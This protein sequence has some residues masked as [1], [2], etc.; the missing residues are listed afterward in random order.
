MVMIFSREDLVKFIH[1][2]SGKIYIYGI[3]NYGEI[4]ATI[5]DDLNIKFSAF[6]V[7]DDKS[8][9]FHNHKVYSFN[10]IQKEIGKDDCIL[11]A[12]KE[13]FQKE[14]IDALPDGFL[15][16]IGVLNRSIFIEYKNN[17][18]L[19][20]LNELVKKYPPKPYCGYKDFR[21]IL[22]VRLDRMGDMVWTSAFFRELRRNFP[23][24]QIT[25]L[26]GEKN[27]EILKLCPYINGIITCDYERIM[28]NS[29]SFTELYKFAERFVEVNI[30]NKRF[31][32][33][34][35]ARGL[36]NDK[37]VLNTFLAVLAS[38]SIRI[39][40]DYSYKPNVIDESIRKL[41]SVVY[42]HSYPM[43]DVEKVLGMLTSIDCVV[44]RDNLEVWFPAR[45]LEEN[46]LCKKVRESRHR[47]K[48][49]IAVG[50]ISQ[51]ENKIWDMKLY[52]EL[53]KSVAQEL[54]AC[55]V[56][57][58]GSDSIRYAHDA[59]YPDNCINLAGKTNLHE[60]MKIISNC[61]IYLGAN[62]GIMHIAAALS[63]PVIEISAHFPWGNDD[64]GIAPKHCGAWR[65]KYTVLYPSAPESRKC[66]D[67]GQCV[68]KEGHCINNV[69]VDN[70]KT[71]L[72]DFLLYY[73]Y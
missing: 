29:E 51:D 17:E 37:Y 25:A 54:S 26:I 36:L 16:G 59:F 8:Y 9:A 50:L 60:L 30:K 61:D 66:A 68:Y 21:K 45:L 38:D 27:F 5:L 13:E 72:R 40:Y 14:V 56:L 57:L 4:C 24:A 7:T 11:L 15:G 70:V 6:I 28:N 32:V 23:K 67:A 47:Y 2:H 10:N 20:V 49:I 62:T 73:H 1:K 44:K 33:V 64:M 41:Y 63:K 39:G 65:T 31:D 19:G 35:N 52:R 53:F 48:H 3:G 43:H 18:I 42:K 58:G 46:L 34:F 69:T 22:V 71:L 12:M 55:F